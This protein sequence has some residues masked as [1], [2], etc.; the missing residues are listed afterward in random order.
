MSRYLL[1]QDN[2]EIL[3]LLLLLIVFFF[4]LFFFSVYTAHTGE[5]T[6]SFP[7][8][9]VLSFCTSI[10]GSVLFTLLYLKISAFAR[11]AEQYA[12]F[13]CLSCIS[14]ILCFQIWSQKLKFQYYQNLN[15][16]KT[17]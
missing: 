14:G 10:V 5:K 1:Q 9:I 7:L 3:Q 8:F 12:E 6:A 15:L 13:F 11:A 4:F 2:D 16:Y 17:F